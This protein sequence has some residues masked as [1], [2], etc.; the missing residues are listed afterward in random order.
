MIALA[1]GEDSKSAPVGE[2][3]HDR[4]QPGRASF[5]PRAP[6]W[7][8][9]TAPTGLAA[10]MDAYGAIKRG[11]VQ[12]LRGSRWLGHLLRGR[13]VELVGGPHGRA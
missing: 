12:G 5:P 2:S 10:L 9:G 7:A 4:Q 13:V 6:G 11:T 8:R 1:A 3:R